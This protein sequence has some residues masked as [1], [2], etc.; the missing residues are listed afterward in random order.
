MSDVTDWM[1]E[2]VKAQMCEHPPGTCHRCDDKRQREQ[3]PSVSD[4]EAL[5]QRGDVDVEILP[6][7]SVKTAPKAPADIPLTEV[8]KLP[9]FY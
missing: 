6:D 5:M 1:H 7:G 2:Q 8:A 3:Q 9:S 4:I